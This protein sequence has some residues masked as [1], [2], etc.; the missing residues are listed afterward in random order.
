MTVSKKQVIMFGFQFSL[1]I[2][3]QPFLVLSRKVMSS[4]PKLTCFF[5]DRY[6]QNSNIG[7]YPTKKPFRKRF[8]NTFFHAFVPIS[9]PFPSPWPIKRFYL[10]KYILDCHSILEYLILSENNHPS[11]NHDFLRKI[12]WDSAVANFGWFT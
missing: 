11:I 7:M 9:G 6:C 2:Q 3:N 10:Q 12:D 1:R 5:T 4:S 8:V